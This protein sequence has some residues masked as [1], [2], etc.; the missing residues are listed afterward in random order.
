MGLNVAVQ[1]DPVEHVNIDGDSTFVMGL[2]AQ[3]RGHKLFYYHPRHLTL[4][5]GQVTARGHK[6]ELRRE[7]GNHFTLGAREKVDLRSFDVV[8]M[9]QDPPFDMAYITATHILEHI[10]PQVLV[11]NDPVE[12]RNAPEKLFVAKFD[13]RSSPRT[14]RRSWLSAPGTRT[15]SSSRSTAMAAPASS[16]S[17]RATRIWAR[18]WSSSPSSTASR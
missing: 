17:R 4:Q 12:V 1:M 9:R 16:T 3:E 5:D 2:A 13:G 15:S 18:C 8:L 7:R 11:V 14:A 10:H 6:L